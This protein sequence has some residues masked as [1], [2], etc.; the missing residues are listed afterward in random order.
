MLHFKNAS[1]RG[2]A[3]TF[4]SMGPSETGFLPFPIGPASNFAA[5]PMRNGNSR[6]FPGRLRARNIALVWFQFR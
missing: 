3:A 6:S 2:I 1:D 4:R 5:F